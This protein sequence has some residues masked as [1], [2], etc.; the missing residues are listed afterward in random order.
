[1]DSGAALVSVDGP[2]LGL[3]PVS[4]GSSEAADRTAPF[5]LLETPTD[6]HGAAQP[7]SVSDLDRALLQSLSDTIDVMESLDLASWRDEIRAQL[8]QWGDPPYMPPGTPDRAQ[9][10][11]AR[12]ERV[13]AVIEL[14]SDDEGGSRTAAEMAH[15]AT[16]LRE[17]GRVARAAHAAA[18]NT[19]V[20]D[21][22]SRG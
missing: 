10:L 21:A 13:L 3:V 7:E 18:W 2:S 11:A 14:A 12:S 5:T 16:M 20:I 9:R 22:L 17:L 8:L 1:M 19:G 4:A 15:R 6:S